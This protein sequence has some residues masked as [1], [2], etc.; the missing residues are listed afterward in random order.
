MW[1]R[2]EAEKRREEKY[3][4]GQKGL[5]DPINLVSCQTSI[6]INTDCISVAMIQPSSSPALNPAEP[7]WNGVKPSPAPETCKRF[8]PNY[9]SDNN[10]SLD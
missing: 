5:T 4:I 3:V 6:R 7:N 10:C 2:G 8:H 1:R 9:R